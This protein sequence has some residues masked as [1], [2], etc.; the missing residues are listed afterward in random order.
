MN[1]IILIPVYNEEKT[2]EIVLNKLLLTLNK[3]GKKYSQINKFKI[4]I[5]DDCSYD[6]TANKIQKFLKKNSK[7]KIIINY[8]KS[9]KEYWQKSNC[10]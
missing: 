3:V 2:I 6:D 9:E 10:L 5:L 1:L 4:Y 7:N 8:K